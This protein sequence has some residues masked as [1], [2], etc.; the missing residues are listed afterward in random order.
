EFGGDARKVRDASVA[1]VVRALG[2]TREKFDEDE[3]R[4]LS[5]LALPLALIPDLAR[6]TVE[7]KRAVAAIVRAKAGRDELNY[8][9]LLR[10]HAR[11]RRAIIALGTS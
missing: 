3:R 9:R 11:L 6:W 1:E 8:L 10:R 2:A 5:N 7:E 4:A